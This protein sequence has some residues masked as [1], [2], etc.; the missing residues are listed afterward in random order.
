MVEKVK[1]ECPNC[2]KPI[3]LPIVIPKAVNGYR[4]QHL[5]IDPEQF[6]VI[7]GG[8]RL[9][10]TATEHRLLA[11]LVANA[12][13]ILTHKQILTSVWGWEYQDDVDYVRIYIWRLRHKIEPE[14]AQP[15][16]IISENGIGYYFNNRNGMGKE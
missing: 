8:Q 7:V 12:G 5:I 2:H 6:L 11:C 9:K 3:E 15:R 16:Y 14:P 13:R 1:I 4:D 10:L